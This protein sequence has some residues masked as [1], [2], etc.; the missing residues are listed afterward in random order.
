[1]GVVASVIEA[2]G[3]LSPAGHASVGLVDSLEGLREDWTRL[4]AESG[5]VF[6]TWEWNDLWWRHYGG[7]RQLRVAVSTQ[8]DGRIDSVVPLFVWA[9]R[10]LRIVRLIGH[11]HGDRLGPICANDAQSEQ[12]ALRRALDAHPHDLFV[13]DWVAGDRDWAGVLQGRVVRQTGYPILR[14]PHG[15][16]TE[17]LA[18]QS[19]RLR[20][21][22]RNSRNRL[23]RDHQVSYRFADSASL[24]AD[25]DTA[26]RL[27][28][29]RFRAHPGCLFCGDHEPFQREFASLALER[30]WLRLFLMELDG[31]PAAFE[32]G[33]MFG[34]AYFAYQGGRDPAWDKHSIG[35]VLELESIRRSVEQGATEYRFLGG[36]EGY[37]YRFA[38][39][40]PG[41]E[42]VVASA[43]RRGSI[44]GAAV[45]AL[46]HAPGG[47]A[48]L[49]RIATAKGSS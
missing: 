39:E 47:K 4:A 19:Q 49:R 15:S 17:F 1:M 43:T 40:D 28:R 42:T 16:W 36:E 7:E 2:P 13:G 10:P 30:G 48:A 32:Y 26:F 21:S 8:E 45:D 23:E 9:R 27:H 35:F 46:W 20:K 14:F 24:E 25:L 12:R 37:K 34:D 33:F 22:A 29:I 11:G 41:L 6:A 38:T 18:G 44:A 3:S 31:T 5:N